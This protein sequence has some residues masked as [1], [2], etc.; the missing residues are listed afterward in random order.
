MDEFFAARKSEVPI[1]PFNLRQEMKDGKFDKSYV[2]LS[3]LLIMKGILR[4]EEQET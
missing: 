3:S 2:L 4:V 1:E